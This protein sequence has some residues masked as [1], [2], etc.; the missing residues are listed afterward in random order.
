MPEGE[1]VPVPSTLRY[2]NIPVP[3]FW[4]ELA[5]EGMLCPEVE[6]VACFQSPVV[7]TLYF[8]ITQA[9]SQLKGAADVLHE[10]CQL[11]LNCTSTVCA[12]LLRPVREVLETVI[13]LAKREDAIHSKEL[14]SK[15]LMGVLDCMGMANLTKNQLYTLH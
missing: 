9:A 8:I 12:V 7:P 5:P 11:R 1:K 13:L 15:V 2:I 14:S 3:S 10:F 4:V 6:S